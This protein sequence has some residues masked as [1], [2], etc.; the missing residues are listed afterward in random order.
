MGAPAM[1]APA[2]AMAPMEAPGPAFGAPPAGMPGAM[3]PAGA[4][5]PSPAA[6]LSAAARGPIGKTRSPIVVL[7]LGSITCGLYALW[8]VYSMANEL[9]AFRRK[10]DVNPILCLVY[11]G[12]FAVPDAVV[13]ARQL[14]GMAPGSPPNAILYILLWWW[15]LVNDLNEIW[16]A[17][18]RS[19]G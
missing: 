13:E 19:G 9:N 16:A 3:S 2:G 5:A 10:N 12:F 8:T 18:Q 1:G 7:L 6:G 14:A 15:F 11:I 4:I 17:A